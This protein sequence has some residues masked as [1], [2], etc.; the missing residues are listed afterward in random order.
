MATNDSL[1][2]RK[3][4]PVDFHGQALTIVDKDG[5]PYVA[6]KPIVEGMGISWQGQHRKL[7]DDSDRWGINMM[8]IPSQGGEQ[9]TL[10][11]PLRKLT[12]W[13]MTLQPSRMDDAVAAKVL[14]YQNEC[15]DALWDYWTKGVA[16]NPRAVSADPTAMGLPDFRKPTSAA[17]AWIEQVERAEAAEATVKQLEAKAAIDAPMVQF[18]QRICEVPG[19]YLV[20]QIAKMIQQ[21]TGEPCGTIRLYTWMRQVHLLHQGGEQKNDPTQRSLDAGW[22]VVQ[23]RICQLSDGREKVTRTTRVTP[24][25]KAYLYGR[26][27]AI[28][29]ANGHTP[30]PCPDE[31]PDDAAHAHTQLSLWDAPA[32]L[33]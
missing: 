21:G 5:Q 13:L 15:D 3:L 9:A 31:A 25:G 10:F 24:K 23:E 26:W 18:A 7:T 28:A 6:M 22:F 2:V 30:G 4:D 11:M 8:L 12:A 17:R 33:C 32:L 14:V 16:V 19:T 20:G 29:R 1:V 27:A